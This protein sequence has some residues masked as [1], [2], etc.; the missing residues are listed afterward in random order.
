M[1]IRD[2]IE[3]AVN[4]WGEPEKN[5]AMLLPYGLPPLDEALYGI[6]IVDGELIA[7]QGL[8]KN[9]KTTL[10]ANIVLSVMLSGTLSKLGYS[11][12][13]DTLESGETVERYRDRLIGMLAT[14]AL[15][16]GE[17]GNRRETWNVAGV[18]E[19][20]H[21]GMSPE[22]LRYANRSAAQQGAIEH[23]MGIME[24]WPLHIFGGSRYRDRFTDT[25]NLQESMQR[26]GRLADEENAAI[27]ATD[28]IQLYNLPGSMDYQKQERVIPALS[29]HQLATS[30]AV[31]ALS[32]I[33]L[34]S[35]KD[36]KS[37]LMDTMYAK[38]GGRLAAEANAVIQISYDEANCK[39]LIDVP[40]SRKARA[41]M[42]QSLEPTSGLFVGRA[43]PI[44]RGSR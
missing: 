19:N 41:K 12:V 24:D 17:H 31:I 21:L 43:I 40:R 42:H 36:Y 11:M 8:E 18:L 38:G 10:L 27:F 7:I 16:A 23:A 33:S 37:G 25:R 4:D 1:K 34:G 39:V 35:F 6:N 28:H 22:Y 15:L 32:Q 20:D 5:R 30:T 13:L 26:W 44:G 14:Y 29:S 3:A 9:R 2:L